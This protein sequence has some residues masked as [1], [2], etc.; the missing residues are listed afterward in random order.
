[1]VSCERWSCIY[2]IHTCR[3]GQLGQKK[4]HQAFTF[5]SRDS[6]LPILFPSLVYCWAFVTTFSKRGH[7][8]PA[9]GVVK[10]EKA[11]YNSNKIKASLLSLVQWS[12]QLKSSTVYKHT[13]NTHVTSKSTFCQQ[14]LI[15]RS[16]Y[17]MRRVYKRVTFIQYVQGSMLTTQGLG[18]GTDRTQE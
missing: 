10:S 7:F 12:V 18:I 13:C 6:F 11:L 8:W 14:L 4:Q 5:S 17:T 9:W 2:N 1:M 16:D 3:L 15:K